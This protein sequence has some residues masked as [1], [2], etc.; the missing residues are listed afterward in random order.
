[1]TR[2]ITADSGSSASARSTCSGP[3]AS[4]VHSAIDHQPFVAGSA[5]S[6]ATAMTAHRPGHQHGG[7]GDGLD[8]AAAQAA[9]QRRGR[10]R[11]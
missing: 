1:M 5:S 3:T 7:D 8:H 4:S 11:R 6:R 10:R 2:I 9:L